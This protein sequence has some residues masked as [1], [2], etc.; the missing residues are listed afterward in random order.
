MAGQ[1]CVPKS[2]N[3][4]VPLRMPISQISAMTTQWNCVLCS[5]RPAV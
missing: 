4:L 1:E 3:R 5:A 2:P